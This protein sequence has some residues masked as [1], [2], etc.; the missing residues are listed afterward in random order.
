MD[1]LY[2]VLGVTIDATTDEIKKAHRD[3][4][5]IWHPDK[6][7]NNQN[8][9]EEVEKKFRLINNSYSV[10]SDPVKRTQYDKYDK[11]DIDRTDPNTLQTF[12]PSNQIDQM[13]EDNEIPPVIVQVNC[14]MIEAYNGIEK[15]VTFNRFSPC[16]QCDGM[17]TLDRKISKCRQCDGLGRMI[18]T[19]E[20]GRMGF[21]INSIQCEI[22]SGKGIDPDD[23]MC[24][25]CNGDR[26]IVEEIEYDLEIHCGAHHQEVVYLKG[27]GNYIPADERKNSIQR[28]DVLFVINTPMKQTINQVEYM[29]GVVIEKLQKIDHHNLMIEME[30]SLAES[31]CGFYREIKHIDESVIL[32]RYDG[33]VLS[34]DI[35][36]SCGKGMP[37]NGQTIT[38]DKKKEYG[39]LLIR[40]SIRREDLDRK[41]KR[42]LWQIITNTGF[43]RELQKKGECMMD[44]DTWIDKQ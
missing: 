16:D 15:N 7:R 19:S 9:A 28:T 27:E 39:D 36:I 32:I 21:L 12:D 38:D 4:I 41:Q 2:N 6:N 37:K 42:R 24:S 22:C 17:G 14:D 34:N 23:E 8:S 26:Y 43:N 44:Y 31:L 13:F 30:I 20:G 33:L 1:N 40:F 3:L 11:Y 35:H 29:R 25:D 5:R 18:R 10:L